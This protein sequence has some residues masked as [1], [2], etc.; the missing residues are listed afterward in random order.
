M[1][2]NREGDPTNHPRYRSDDRHPYPP[3]PAILNLGPSSLLDGGVA[4]LLDFFYHR[5]V[6]NCTTFFL[7]C[8]L[9]G[10]ICCE[11][12]WCGEIPVGIQPIELFLDSGSLL[13][14]AS[15]GRPGPEGRQRIFVVG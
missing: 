11:M 13:R 1:G 8:L 6:N 15:A 12:F 10:V 4:A 9:P 7:L 2:A 3:A 5:F 14:R